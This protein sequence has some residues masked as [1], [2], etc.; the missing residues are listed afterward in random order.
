MDVFSKYQEIIDK[1][2]LGLQLIK[3]PKQL[4]EPIEYILKLGGKRI[5]PAM[6][7]ASCNYFSGNYSPA[8]Q[9]ALGLELFHNFTLLHDDIMDNAPIRRNKSTVHE[10]WNPNTAILSGDAMMVK[11]SQMILDVPEIV[12]KDVQH[13]FYDT[14]L[15]VCEGQQ[16]D[17]DFETRLDVSIEDYIEMIR[18]KTAVL[19]GASLQIG[20]IIGGASKADAKLLYDFGQSIGIAFQLQDD[21][22]DVYGNTDI[23]GKKV[24]QDIISNK[25]TF[26]LIS[27]LNLAKGNRLS[28]LKKWLQK[29]D[30][31]HLEKV[32]A[33]KEIYDYYQVDKIS[34]EKMDL[35]IENSIK[36]LNKVNISA[37]YKKELTDFASK[38]IN[39]SN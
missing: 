26:L 28:E 7:I 14:A 39:R 32:T 1:E 36:L 33:I 38:L 4:Y 17:M 31:N 5:R 15:E 19:L 35:Y 24:G 10:K 21:Y 30:F 18:L 2:I 27:C 22:L 8:I 12:L 23:F 25:K 13:I 20:S 6:C 9:A 37:D 3:A 16:Y 11:A 34:R 29:D